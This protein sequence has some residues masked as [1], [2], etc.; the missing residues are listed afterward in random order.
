MD[1]EA[2]R[3]S[4]RYD[5]SVCKYEI[6]DSLWLLCDPYVASKVFKVDCEIVLNLKGKCKVLHYDKL[7]LYVGDNVLKWVKLM[8]HKVT[9]KQGMQHKL[10]STVH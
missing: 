10:L 6:C 7:K 5:G 9:S 4:E 2:D 1:K 8:K 3:Q